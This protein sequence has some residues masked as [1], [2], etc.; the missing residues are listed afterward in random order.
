MQEAADQ[1]FGPGLRRD[2]AFRRPVLQLGLQLGAGLLGAGEQALKVRF[3]QKAAE[4]VLVEPVQTGR[5]K[6]NF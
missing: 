4:P 3:W 2:G 5:Q 1:F 6:V